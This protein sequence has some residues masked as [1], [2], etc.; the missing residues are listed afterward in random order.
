MRALLKIML[1]PI[2]LILNIVLLLAK[3][4]IYVAGGIMGVLSIVCLLAAFAGITN[5]S[6]G[7]MVT[8]ALITAL[9]LSPVGLPLIAVFLTANLEIFKDWVKAI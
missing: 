1:L 7:Y 9:L 3:G 6:Y 5:D 2:V 4:I 8:P